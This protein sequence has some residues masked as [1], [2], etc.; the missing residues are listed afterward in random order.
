MEPTVSN[1]VPVLRLCSLH[2]SPNE[3]IS[4]SQQIQ[5]YLGIQLN[6]NYRYMSAC[7]NDNIGYIW[8]RCLK[9]N[10]DVA[11]QNIAQTKIF[12]KIITLLRRD[13]PLT[14]LPDLTQQKYKVEIRFESPQESG[15]VKDIDCRAELVVA[16]F[17]QRVMG[18]QSSLM[19]CYR[20]ILASAL[21]WHMNE[22]FKEDSL[23]HLKA[24]TSCP[25]ILE[26]FG[27]STIKLSPGGRMIRRAS[28]NHIQRLMP[29][30]EKKE[31]DSS[32]PC[33]FFKGLS[34]DC[35][36]YC[37]S[38]WLGI[39][40][41][42]L[43]YAKLIGLNFLEKP[44][45]GLLVEEEVSRDIA[46]ELSSEKLAYDIARN[47]RFLTVNNSSE[48]HAMRF[49]ELL[50]TL[51][52]GLRIKYNKKEEIL[53]KW[54]WHVKKEKADKNNDFFTYAVIQFFKEDFNQIGTDENKLF[55]LL[56]LMRQRIYVHPMTV[57][58]GALRDIAHVKF[59]YSHP[60]RV[61]NYQFLENSAFKYQ[62]S[63]FASFTQD[64]AK[65]YDPPS[66]LLEMKNSMSA[67]LEDLNTWSSNIT[68]ELSLLHSEKE[69]LSASKDLLDQKVCEPLKR[70]GFSVKIV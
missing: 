28:Q 68:I 45:I 10:E 56:I 57:I 1:K 49:Q 53:E 43:E 58:G 26:E 21:E 17:K 63:H 29:A 13:K 24:T 2:L 36:D 25:T 5:S 23:L 48:N 61:M 22:F 15:L 11:L 44:K 20:D 65:K 19:R 31:E 54:N 27:D 18:Q 32:I 70:L 4:P 69:K 33:P 67:S 66:F 30:F 37:R 14:S 51:M 39:K 40:V 7:M 60:S 42:E 38:Y 59:E 35:L 50:K 34:M 6:A 8:S 41:L 46:F 12:N 62:V 55:Q 47:I 9:E 16:I 64:V 52:V 3:P